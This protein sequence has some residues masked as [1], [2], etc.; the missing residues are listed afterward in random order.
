MI[1]S[2]IIAEAG[3]NHNGSLSM[4]KQ[5][6]DVAVSAGVDIVKFQTYKTKNLVT[7]EAKQAKYQS[8]NTQK[9]ESQQQMLSRLELSFAEHIE[10][11][12]YCEAQNI[13]YLSTAFDSDSLKFLVEDLQLNKLKI[14][15]GEITNAPFIL[16]HA[17]SGCDLIMSTGMSTLDE[18]QQALGVIAFGL[19]YPNNEKQ[20]SQRLF[21]ESFNS[22]EGKKK[23]LEKVSLLH[24]TTEYPAPLEHVNL[25]AMSLMKE[26]YNLPVGYSDHT[27]GIEV[28][29]IAVAHGACIIEKHFTLSRELEGP[30]HKASI[31]PNELLEMVKNIRQSELIIGQQ[32]KEPSANEIQNKQVIRKSIV[33]KGNIKK[34]EVLNENNLAIMRPGY[35]LS[36]ENFWNVLNSKAIKDFNA[37]D[38]IVLT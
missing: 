4:A 17:Q 11:K 7:A 5:L 6:V 8:I 1:S 27:E 23:L 16:E 34:G 28:P 30:D 29:V 15:S 31:E 9:E 12:K 3:V 22:D 18:I 26:T 13:E 33:A 38:L 14:P 20:P 37:G 2:L 10:L 36:P 21:I 25:S 32:I 35:G 24:C 19:L